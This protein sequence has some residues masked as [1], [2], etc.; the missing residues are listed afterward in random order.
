MRVPIMVF[1]IVF[2]YLSTIDSSTFG[3]SGTRSV[4]FS[5]GGNGNS[6]GSSGVGL[7]SRNLTGFDARRLSRT[8]REFLHQQRL[9][10]QRAQAIELQR[11]QTEAAKA[12]RKQELIQLGL[13][14]NG[15][16]N[17]QQY[18][19]AF[20][21]AKNDYRALRR[22]Q[23]SPNHLGFLR[24][25]FR[26]RS[27]TIDRKRRTTVWPDALLQPKFEPQVQNIS[28]KLINGRILDAE[29]ANEF[30]NDL[31]QLNLDLNV[32]AANGEIGST[33]YARSRRFVSGLANDVQSSNLIM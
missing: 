8:E 16:L 23:L 4:P 18:R 27:D 29:S 26:L 32:A 19:R 33:D 10:Q 17:K 9:A 7:S 31:Y 5:R 20:A 15:N 13:N 24:Q 14:L 28:S 3:Q 2:V 25:S 11:L 12:R 21:E 1:T 30:L 6:V 22:L